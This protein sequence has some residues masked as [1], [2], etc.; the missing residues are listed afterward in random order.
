MHAPVS[1]MPFPSKASAHALGAT[2]RAIGLAS[3]FAACVRDTRAQERAGHEEATLVGQRL[4]VSARGH[5]LENA[6]ALPHSRIPDVA[7]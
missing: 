3:R 6:F 7:V 1:V 2:M 5:P 4:Q